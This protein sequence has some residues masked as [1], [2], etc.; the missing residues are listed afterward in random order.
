MLVVHTETAAPTKKGGKKKELKYHAETGK[1]GG[2]IWVI[3]GKRV[4]SPADLEKHFPK[5]KYSDYL[6]FLVDKKDR[7]KSD[8]EDG[9]TYAEI[10]KDVKSYGE[11]ASIKD[12]TEI[13]MP[14]G[15]KGG[16]KKKGPLRT[17]IFRVEEI[18]DMLEEMQKWGHGAQELD[19][20]LEKG[21]STLF[22]LVTEVH[23]EVM[24]E[25]AE[26]VIGEDDDDDNWRPTGG[27]GKHSKKSKMARGYYDRYPIG[28]KGKKKSKRSLARLEDPYALTPEEAA[29]DPTGDADIEAAKPYKPRRR[30]VKFKRLKASDIRK[31][32][33]R[34]RRTKV[35]RKLYNKNYRRKFARKIARNAQRRIKLHIKLKKAKKNYSRDFTK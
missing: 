11:E 31:K 28:G 19:K 20:R 12:K 23:N 1:N 30:V 6:F 2:D 17:Q 10:L 4:A 18:L 21:I 8:G 16:K 25:A 5:A 14:F 13:A 24:E 15:G 34:L 35:R 3:A 7:R 22:T 33:Q 26:D 27:K 9:Y 32:K 29:A